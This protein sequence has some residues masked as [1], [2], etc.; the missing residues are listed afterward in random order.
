M[1]V[2]RMTAG[3]SLTPLSVQLT[4]PDENGNAVA[5]NLSTISSLVIKF[6]MTDSEGDIVIAETTHGVTIVTAA[7][8]L[9]Q[10]EFEEVDVVAGEYDA[11]FRVYSGTK[12]DT[13][14]SDGGSLKV[15]VI[16]VI[17]VAVP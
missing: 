15:R 5:V 9:V 12:F 1:S 3:D 2:H 16:D 7:D 17:P 11:W 4:Q 6:I 10:Y 8:G 13:Y 14:P